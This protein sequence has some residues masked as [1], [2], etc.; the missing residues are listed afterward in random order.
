MA[1]GSVWGSYVHG[2]FDKGAFARAFVDCLLQAKGLEPAADVEDWES[3]KARQYDILA[4]GVR[5]ALDMDQIYRI[6][7][8]GI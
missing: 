5:K 4:D 7:E 1:A 6:L 8:E 3:Y 2:I